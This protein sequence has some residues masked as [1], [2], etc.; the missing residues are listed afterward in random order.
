VNDGRRHARSDADHRLDD[1]EDIDPGMAR[2]RTVLA[3]SRT[4]LSFLA[5]GGVVVRVD[6]LTGLTV[7]ALGGAVWLIGYFHHRS[8]WVAARPAQWLTRPRTLRLVAVGTAA[9]ALVTLVIAV[10]REGRPP[11]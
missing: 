1:M 5:L 3:W 9:V 8:M 7:V 4:G 11:L 2:E 10:L 6:L